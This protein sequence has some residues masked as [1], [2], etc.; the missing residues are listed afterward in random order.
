M[1][2]ASAGCLTTSCPTCLPTPGLPLDNA[3]KP[4]NHKD[5][6]QKK[7]IFWAKPGGEYLLDI[8]SSASLCSI[9]RETPPAVHLA[10][11]LPYQEARRRNDCFRQVGAQAGVRKSRGKRRIGIH[12]ACGRS[13]NAKYRRRS[14]RPSTHAEGF[15]GLQGEVSESRRQSHVYQRARAA[16]A[17]QDQGDAGGG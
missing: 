15:R 1:R 2:S 3:R 10:G 7:P 4:L 14:R 17:R 9:G 13:G 6:P 16:I 11:G 5:S 12:R 8:G